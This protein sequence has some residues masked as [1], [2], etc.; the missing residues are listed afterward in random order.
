VEQSVKGVALAEHPAPPRAIAAAT[1]SQ[2]TV[3][4]VRS[5]ELTRDDAAALDRL[6]EGRPELGVFLSRAWLSGHFADPPPGF[7]PSLVLLRH[8]ADLKGVAPIAVRRSSWHVKVC[9]LGGGAGSDRTDLLAGAGF[10]AGCADALISWVRT[11]FDGRAV[12]VEL[13]DVPAD[14]PLWGA[15]YRANA[16][17]AGRFVLQ[18]RQIHTLPY[19]PLGPGGAAAAWS[20]R[21]LDKHRRWLERRGRLEIKLLHDPAETMDAFESLAGFLHA[22]WRGHDGGSVL[23][24]PARRGFHR[25]AIPRLLA[26]NRL[27]MIRLSVDG[28]TVAVFYGLAGSGW[29]GYY[30]AGFDREWAGRIH[31]GQI[32]LAAAIEIAAHEGASQFDFLKGAY[33]IKYLWPV[34][35]RSTFDA[36]LYSGEARAQLARAL[37]ATRETAAALAKSAGS[38]F[39]TTNG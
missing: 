6:L 9:L 28:R 26:E 33:S 34:R 4:S 2:I 18:P 32:T 31:L 16:E 21:S 30:L 39:V 12:I 3:E 13:R 22:R 14:S 7:E 17:P 27:R 38:W 36:D 15:M 29:W 24:D 23:D 8:G 37:R 35:D 25:R 20:P 11:A 5:L 10:E 19:L 1:A